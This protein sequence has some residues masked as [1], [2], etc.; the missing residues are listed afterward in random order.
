MTIKEF[1]AKY[2]LSQ[3]Q[4]PS[5]WKPAMFLMDDDSAKESFDD[6]HEFHANTERTI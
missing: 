3:M 6:R 4:F 1:I 2:S 5:G